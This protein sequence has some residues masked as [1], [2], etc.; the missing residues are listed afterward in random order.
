MLTHVLLLEFLIIF[1]SCIH[2]VS[3]AFKVYNYNLVQS[4]D[5]N[6]TLIHF[7]LQE[8]KQ[9]FQSLVNLRKISSQEGYAYDI[10]FPSLQSF[11][12]LTLSFNFLLLELAVE[13]SNFFGASNV[14]ISDKPSS[15]LLMPPHILIIPI[16]PT[17]ISPDNLPSSIPSMLMIHPPQSYKTYGTHPSD[18]PTN[19]TSSPNIP[20]TLQHQPFA[21]PKSPPFFHA[22]LQSRH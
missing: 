22:N 4:V 10:N 9:N 13:V 19:S 5:C 20:T 7:N 1:L 3:S 12:F 11:N 15:I 16:K 8:T 18:P 6:S 14:T 17:P 2:P 21:N